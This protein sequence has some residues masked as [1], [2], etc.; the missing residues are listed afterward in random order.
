MDDEQKLDAVS[1]EA[2]SDVVEGEEGRG[3]TGDAEV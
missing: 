2:E 1:P 3:A